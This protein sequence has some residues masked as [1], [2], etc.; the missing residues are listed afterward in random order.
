MWFF[1]DFVDGMKGDRKMSKTG[2]ENGFRMIKDGTIEPKRQQDKT[3]AKMFQFM[4][5]K[6][7]GR[8]K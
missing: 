8:R 7:G 5:M 3:R 1:V 6:K 2:S 4:K